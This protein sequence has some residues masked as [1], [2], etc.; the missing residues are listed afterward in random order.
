MSL[1]I[2]YLSVINTVTRSF[3]VKVSHARKKLNMSNLK[4]QNIKNL[5]S[6]STKVFYTLTQDKHWW[7]RLKGIRLTLLSSI[8]H[9]LTQA[10]I[11]HDRLLL[12]WFPLLECPFH[13]HT[14]TIPHQFHHTNFEKLLNSL[15]I[16]IWAS[17]HNRRGVQ[18]WPE[19]HLQ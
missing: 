17:L 19:P 14:W 2:L 15:Q 13:L 18:S 11:H 6:F 8:F 16:P 1:L 3:V 12:H 4:E 9:P 7:K 10:I 5:W